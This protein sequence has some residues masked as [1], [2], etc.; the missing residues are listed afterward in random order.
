MELLTKLIT[1]GVKRKI[2]AGEGCVIP[3]LLLFLKAVVAETQVGVSGVLDDRPGCE[4]R[5]DT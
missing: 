2:T 1:K 5:H 3:A 4:S